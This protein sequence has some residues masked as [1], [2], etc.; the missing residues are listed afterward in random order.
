M[1]LRSRETRGSG[2]KT[3]SKSLYLGDRV[4]DL[5]PRVDL[6]EENLGLLLLRLRYRLCPVRV[7][8]R[9]GHQKL[10]RRGVDAAGGLDKHERVAL[11][12][13]IGVPGGIARQWAQQTI[14]NG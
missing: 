11:W 6:K 3:M 9:D 10:D 12:C 13:P 1:A 14:Q 5:N 7:R 4:F 2:P 8:V